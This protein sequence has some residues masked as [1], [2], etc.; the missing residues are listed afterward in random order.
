MKTSPET[1]DYS[2]LAPRQQ[3]RLLFAQGYSV[4]EITQQL[5]QARSTVESWK[6][7]DQWK[8]ADIYDDVTTGLRGRLLVVIS[9]D[10]KSNADYKELDALFRQLERTARIERYRHGGTES[11]LNPKLLERNASARKKKLKNEITEDQLDRLIKAFEDK[12]FSYQKEWVGSVEQSRSWLLLKSRQ[13]G[14]T[15]TFAMWALIDGLKTG[16]NKIFM[17]ASKAQAYQFIEY[18]KA[19]VLE[20]TDI[21]LVGDPLVI[22]GPNGQFT[23]YYLGTNALTAQGRHGDTIMDEFMWIRNFA[24]FK[25]VASGMASQKHYRQIYLS[26]PSSILHESYAFWAGKDGKRKRTLEIDVSKAALKRPTACTDGKTR[27]IVSLD[28]A[29]AAGC[30]LFNRQ[31]LLDEYSDDE[32]ENLFN[33]EFVDDSGSYFP[34][35]I[36]EPNMIDS[37]EIWKDFKP[38]GTQ[39]YQGPV[40]IGYDPSFSGDNAAL[41]VIAPPQTPM[42]PYRVL[43]HIHFKHLPPHVQAQHIEK[44]CQRYHVEYMAI[45]NTGNGM[46]VAEHVVKFFPALVRLNYNV[47]IKTR[48]ALR[49]KEL[50]TRRRLQFDAGSQDVAKSFLSIKKSLTGSGGQMTLIAS[51]SMETGHA[52]KAWAIMNAL[53]RAPIV[54]TTDPS[55]TGAQRSR[56]RVFT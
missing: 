3:G 7:R 35:A 12:L 36:I 31:N 30:D 23:I 24:T 43:E 34:L 46:S 1:P 4:T 40:W 18:I 9:K 22:N 21:E 16:K 45:D 42:K 28:D 19:F 29:E 5:G 39:P 15:H 38:F 54:D 6:Q 17:S 44:F 53:E 47:E 56:I 55:S 33:C 41:A 27:Q 26:T 14:A 11:D 25:K 37:W 48:M 20:H 32:F 8:L 52:D 10:S 50:L 51:R 2:Q 49:A 13:I